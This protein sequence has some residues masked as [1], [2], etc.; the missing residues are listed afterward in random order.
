MSGLVPK[1][2]CDP[3]GQWYLQWHQYHNATSP[4]IIKPTCSYYSRSCH[5]EVGY[6][7]FEI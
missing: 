3:A 1:E 4:Q 2:S 7:V 6:G 5:N